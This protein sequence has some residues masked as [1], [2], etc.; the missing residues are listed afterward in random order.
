M[1]KE[2]SLAFRADKALVNKMKALSAK[3]KLDR[4]KIV[5]LGIDELFG[6]YL[7]PGY[8][9]E[10]MVVYKRELDRILTAYQHRIAELDP[11]LKEQAKAAKQAEL[12]NKVRELYLQGRK[13][14]AK[15]LVE[16]SYKEGLVPWYF[17][18]EKSDLTR[19]EMLKE[20]YGKDF[21]EK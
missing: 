16:K 5:T 14:E 3:L 2:F 20:R 19:E 7:S 9:G 18:W 8:T 10:M 21:K 6:K 12:G 4:S 13:K 11:K 15:E 1:T 17:E